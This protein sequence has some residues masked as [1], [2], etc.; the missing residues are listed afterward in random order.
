M[1]RVVR[2]NVR[3][4]N[5]KRATLMEFWQLITPPPPPKQGSAATFRRRSSGTSE[6][7][8][9]SPL[10]QASDTAKPYQIYV[11]QRSHADVNSPCTRRC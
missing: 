8:P 5:I 6:I 2:D 9:S 11:K 7:P 10:E 3:M 4:R 1:K